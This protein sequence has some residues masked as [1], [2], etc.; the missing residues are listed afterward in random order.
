MKAADFVYFRATSVA[1]AVNYL[2]EYPGES[3]V[4]AGGQSLMPMLNMRL[5]RLSAL[6]DINHV[7]ELGRL[8][9]KG[10][11]TVA[12]ALLRHAAL[13]TSSLAAERL[14]LLAS[15]VKF[16]GDRQVRNRGTIGGSLVQAD[17]TG[18]MPL[19]CL[20]LGARVR[21]QGPGG[22]REIPM[23]TFYEGSY[24]TTLEFD[25]VLTEIV[26]PKHPQHF[27]FMEFARRHGDFCVLSV[28]A[29][30]NRSPDGRWRD[31]RLGLGGVS[32]T[33]VLAMEAAALLEGSRLTDDDIAAAAQAALAVI[34]PASDIRASAEYR[35][36]LVPV[37]VRRVL[38]KLR[39]RAPA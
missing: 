18:E 35:A 31:L 3:R 24:A 4:I 8:E 33:P 28:A 32:D 15:M 23:E 34:D 38:Q 17:P 19:G 16:V 1:E 26:F 14:P 9:V 25:E 7:P 10:E 6:V 11:E 30:G 21:V 5:W 13:E 39:N 36:H 2:S 20:V 22:V 29:T 12:G 27:A 37:Y